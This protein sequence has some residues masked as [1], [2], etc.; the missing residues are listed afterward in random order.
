MPKANSFLRLKWYIERHP[1]WHFAR[2]KLI[3][4]NH[5]ENALQFED[6]NNYNDAYAIPQNFNTLNSQIP[7]LSDNTF[8]TAC[9][10]ARYLRQKCE[11]GYSIGSSSIKT[12]ELMMAESSGVCSVFSLLFINFCILNRIAVRE[13]GLV[14]KHYN[15]TVGHSF[16]EIYS[17]EHKKWVAIDVSNGIYFTDGVS[18]CP[19]S[20]QEL[21][22]NNCQFQNTAIHTL[23]SI[24]GTRKYHRNFE[25]RIRKMF[26]NNKI[27]FFL[28]TNF[29]IKET[30]KMLNKWNG[31]LPNFA[32]HFLLYLAGSYIKFMQLDRGRL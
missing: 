30:D 28:I 27:R 25:E 31:T 26:F 2:I 24:D 29:R 3:S 6:Y 15:A 20:V 5:N 4:I 19:I 17:T 21:V 32:I 13:W 9:V 7:G 14:D 1:I 10:I 18:A 22:S 11:G 12:L 8:E 23:L 16:N